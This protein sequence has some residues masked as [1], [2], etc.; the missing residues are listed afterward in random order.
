LELE[1]SSNQSAAADEETNSDSVA[2]A[3]TTLFN[4]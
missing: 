2:H 4:K 1:N 3:I